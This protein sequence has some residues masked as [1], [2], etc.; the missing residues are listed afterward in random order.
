MLFQLVTIS[1]TLYRPSNI[2]KK[3]KL[4]VGLPLSE[5]ISFRPVEEY[6]PTG[7]MSRADPT[8]LPRSQEPLIQIGLY[9]VGLAYNRSR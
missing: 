5:I 6:F 9:Y 2:A 8:A 4:Q 7:R 1:L 3:I